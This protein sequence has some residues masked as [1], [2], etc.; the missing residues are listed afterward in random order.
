MDHIPHT[1][2]SPFITLQWWIQ[3]FPEVIANSQSWCANLLFYKF[4]ARN[5]MKMKEFWISRRACIP[6]GPLDERIWIS[7]RAC[8]PG[9]PL[10]LPMH[11]HVKYSP[12][13]PLPHISRSPHM[14][15]TPPISNQPHTP[16][17]SDFSIN[18]SCNIPGHTRVQ[19]AHDDDA[20]KRRL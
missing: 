9:G 11:S 14:I 12:C 10:D 2:H 18:R 8:I 6:G 7:R 16:C 17:T 20:H 4:F 5:C 3:D 13:T 19:G 1:L 15:M